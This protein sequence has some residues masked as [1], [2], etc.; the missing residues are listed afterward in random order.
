MVVPLKQGPLEEPDASLIRPMLVLRLFALQFFH[1]CMLYICTY[2]DSYTCSLQD[3]SYVQA[4]PSERR[5]VAVDIDYVVV[6]Q[7]RAA[8]QAAA[9]ATVV[10][11]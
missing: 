6:V 11:A 1:L 5:S 9:A 4:F 3:G 7:W 2:S 8:V 10:V